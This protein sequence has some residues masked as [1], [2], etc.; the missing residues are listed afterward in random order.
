MIY[1][2]PNTPGAVVHFRDRY[3]NFIGGQWVPPVKGQYFDNV[4]PVNGQAFCQVPGP[5]R[6]TSNWPW[7][8]LMPP[9]PPGAPPR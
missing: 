7:T 8:P 5:R 6:K 9:R 1:A 3:D 4:S 2:N